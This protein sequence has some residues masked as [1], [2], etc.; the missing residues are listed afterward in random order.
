MKAN[1]TREE[2]SEL[3]ANLGESFYDLSSLPLNPNT[4]TDTQNPRILLA[5]E[6]AIVN[7]VGDGRLDPNGNATREQIA[8]MLGRAVLAG[9]SAGLSSGKGNI[10]FLETPLC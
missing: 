10:P 2:F 6:M 8:A 5:Y 3:M 1:V 4:F 9:W 7:G